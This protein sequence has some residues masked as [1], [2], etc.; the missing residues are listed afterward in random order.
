[1][2][3]ATSIAMLV[4]MN[5][6]DPF[7]KLFIQIGMISMIEGMIVIVNDRNLGISLF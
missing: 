6:M 4:Q 7:R 3:I 1:M 5:E 2:R